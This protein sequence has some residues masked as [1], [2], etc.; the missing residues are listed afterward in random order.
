MRLP[1]RALRQAFQ[2][3]VEL[4]SYPLK[5]I[6]VLYSVSQASEPLGKIFRT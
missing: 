1:E 2:A 3:D 5:I 6:R 4:V